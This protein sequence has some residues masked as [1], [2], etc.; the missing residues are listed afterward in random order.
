MPS[1]VAPIR[2][3]AAVAVMAIG[4]NVGIASAS[5]SAKTGKT[6]TTAHTSRRHHV[7]KAATKRRKVRSHTYETMSGRHETGYGKLRAPKW[8][9]AKKPVKTQTPI[10]TTARAT[11]PAPTAPTT[12]T[13]TPQPNG[14]PG[15]WNLVL[16]SEFNTSS[17][18][19]SIWR[20]GWWGTGVTDPVNGAEDDCYNSNNVALSGTALNLSVT[21][22][23]STC[24]GKTY[25]WTGALV[26]TNPDDGRAS[27]GFQYTYGALEARV[28]IPASATGDQIA[29]WPAVWAVDQD[30]DPTIAYGEMDLLEGLNGQ[31][32]YHFH[33]ELAAPG[34][35]DTTLTPGWHTFASNWQPGSITYYYDGTKV[36]QIATG[37]TTTPMYIILNNTVAANQPSLSEA[38][39]MQVQYVRVWQS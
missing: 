37:I 1:F 38:S 24:N 2:T 30:S 29:N 25:P 5:A 16:D 10:A 27:G 12:P 11:S 3:F 31:A 6:K 9:H 33:N 7:E 23:S 20:A 19:T 34:G 4:A 17:L 14:I 26:D 36:G 39:T 22:Q 35:C 32:C 13:T 21:H 8:G 28:Y 18:D 15:N